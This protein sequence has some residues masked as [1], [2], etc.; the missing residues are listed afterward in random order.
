[1]ENAGAGG[2]SSPLFGDS[3]AAVVLVGDEDS[4]CAFGVGVSRL[5]ENVLL[6]N[7]LPENEPLSEEV[8]LPARRSDGG[9]EYVA[10]PVADVLKERVCVARLGR[11]LRAISRSEVR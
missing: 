10:F 8:V 3:I 5:E 2:L 7:L 9:C 6:R 11:T 1:M 4:R